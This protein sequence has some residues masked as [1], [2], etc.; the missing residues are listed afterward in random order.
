MNVIGAHVTG[1]GLILDQT[2]QM[3]AT[4]LPVPNMGPNN[5]WLR[6]SAD[7][8]NWWKKISFHGSAEAA[9][10]AISLPAV[11]DNK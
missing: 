8:I 5:I 3:A 1:A 7:L 9:A 2:N 4:Y 11:G 6:P 10:A